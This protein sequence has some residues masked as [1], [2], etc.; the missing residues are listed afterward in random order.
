[1]RIEVECYAG[2][3]GEETPRVIRFRDRRVAAVEVLDR[4]LAPDHRYFKL[5]GEDGGIYIIRHDV[6]GG[7]WELCVYDAERAI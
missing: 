6:A 4:W 1:M 5:R 3:R 7:Q 2:Y